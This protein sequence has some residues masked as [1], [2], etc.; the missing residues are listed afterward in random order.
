MCDILKELAPE[1]ALGGRY[2]VSSKSEIELVP[3]ERAVEAY[4]KVWNSDKS[5]AVNGHS[6]KLAIPKYVVEMD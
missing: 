3:L 4:Q 2:T 1:F 5:S 6:Q